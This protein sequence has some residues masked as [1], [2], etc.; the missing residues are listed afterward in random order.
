M[1][2]RVLRLSVLVLALAWTIA[3]PAQGQLLSPGK[4]A[5]PHQALEGLRNCTSCHQLG[6]Q[7]V[8]AERC[9]SC[10]ESVGARISAGTG[11]HATVEEGACATC[12][13]DHLGADFALVRFDEKSF[14][15]GSIGYALELS[16]ATLDCRACHEPG[17]IADPVVVAEKAEHVALARTFLGLSGECVGCH[18]DEDPHGNQ[19]GDRA[20]AQCHDAGS[21]ASP[22]E[23]DHSRSAFRL[24]GRHAEVGCAECHGSGV[25]ARYSGLTFATC[26][27]CHADP[28]DGAMVGTC[29]SCHGTEGWNS[30]RG[31][32]FEG[33][34]DHDRTSFALRGAHADAACSACHRTARPPSDELVRMSYLPGTSGRAYPP[35]VA[36]SCASCHVDRHVFPSGTPRWLR[37]ADCHD[38]AAWAPSGFGSARH[39]QSTFQLTGAHATAP[40]VACH[41]DSNRGHTRFTL[42]VPAER[43]ESCHVED[44]PHGGRYA[45]LECAACHTTVAFDEVAFAHA[46]PLQSCGGCH[47]AEDPHADQFVGRDCASCHTTDSFAVESFDH[48]TTRFPLDGAHQGATCGTCHTPDAGLGA[49]VRYRPLGTE[50]ADCHGESR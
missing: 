28:H 33:S 25:T 35:P 49:P 34:F 27:D 4:L 39:E 19:F 6:R 30:L 18:A 50:C 36:Q 17:N 43:C 10:H 41:L 16:H 3:A 26:N 11:Y 15:H 40:C 31:T 48:S 24:E 22:T 37:C 5:A 14:D 21:W 9:L 13:Q 29:A 46:E 12:H 38:E 47:A 42:A 44:D 32:S 23:F 7:G 1:M 20:C 2:R 8:A 45:G